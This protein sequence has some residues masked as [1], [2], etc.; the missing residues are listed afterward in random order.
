MKILSCLR[1]KAIE[2][3]DHLKPFSVIAPEDEAQFHQLVLHL[4]EDFVALCGMH[5]AVGRVNEHIKILRSGTALRI[6]A[7][8][9]CCGYGLS[10]TH[11]ANWQSS[12]H[13]MRFFPVCYFLLNPS[14]QASVMTSLRSLPSPIPQA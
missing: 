12:L 4:L 8:R 10:C 1:S 2:E 3:P 11:Y 13:E 7:V 5:F 9:R 14:E 6:E